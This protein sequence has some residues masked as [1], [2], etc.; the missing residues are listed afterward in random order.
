LAYHDKSKNKSGRIK[1]KH[2]NK[3]TEDEN[4]TLI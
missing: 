4:K 1:D 3:P 2:A